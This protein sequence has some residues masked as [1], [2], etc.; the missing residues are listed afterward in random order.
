MFCGGFDVCLF[1]GPHEIIKGDYN[2]ATALCVRDLAACRGITM[3]EC[4]C[5]TCVCVCVCVYNGGN[6]LL[7]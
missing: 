2:C 3:R 4:V 7:E 1:R 6:N 5:V